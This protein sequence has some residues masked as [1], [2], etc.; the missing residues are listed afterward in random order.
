[1]TIPPTWEIYINLPKF[2]TGH[3]SRRKKKGNTET[4]LQS[5]LVCH[6]FSEI[7]YPQK[8][9]SSHHFPNEN[10]CKLRIYPSCSATP[11]K[12]GWYSRASLSEGISYMVSWTTYLQRT[13]HPRDSNQCSAKRRAGTNDFGERSAMKWPRGHGTGLNY[14]LW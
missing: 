3:E 5:K 11:I 7:G 2:I 12:N 4:N 13:A 8:M 10:C 6:G 1:M 9:I 14:G